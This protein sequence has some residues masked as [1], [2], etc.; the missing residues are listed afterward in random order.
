MYHIISLKDSKCMVI[1]SKIK[2]RQFLNLIH[3]NYNFVVRHNYFNILIT[4]LL[5]VLYLII[6]FRTKFILECT[7]LSLFLANKQ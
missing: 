4:Y 6:M 7:N 5:T 1:D 2:F 3:K